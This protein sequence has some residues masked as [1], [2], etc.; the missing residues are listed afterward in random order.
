MGEERDDRGV[1]QGLTRA[2]ERRLDSITDVVQRSYLIREFCE[3][4]DPEL[5]ALS[6]QA[7]IEA[8][9]KGRSRETWLAVAIALFQES[10]SYATLEEIYRC[11]VEAEHDAV[12]LVLLAGDRAQRKA[13]EGDFRRDDFIENLTL[14]ERKAKAKYKPPVLTPGPQ[15]MEMQRSEK[16]VTL[17]PQSAQVDDHLRRPAGF[18]GYRP[19][20]PHWDRAAV[21]FY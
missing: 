6:F 20:T 11:A 4:N 17:Q 12:R 10:V 16:K 2:L 8:T 21:T 19:H 13:E 9:L 14:G 3:A 15:G 18:T 7:V 5:V 1:A